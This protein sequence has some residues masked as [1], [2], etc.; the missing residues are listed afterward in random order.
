MALDVMDRAFLSLPLN[1]GPLRSSGGMRRIGSTVAMRPPARQGWQNRRALKV[2]N[3]A[4][5]EE[6]DLLSAE[7]TVES[8]PYKKNNGHNKYITDDGHKCTRL[9]ITKARVF[10]SRFFSSVIIEASLQNV[11]VQ[12]SNSWEFSTCILVV[13]IEDLGT[14]G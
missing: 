5:K 13:L 10:T 11:A 8:R 1:A 14:K 3:A 9:F 4:L 6:W 12:S 7:A 2:K